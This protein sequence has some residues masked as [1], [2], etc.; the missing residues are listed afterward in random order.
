MQKWEKG[1]DYGEDFVKRVL[2]LQRKY[3]SYEGNAL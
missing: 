3:P 1:V 2:I